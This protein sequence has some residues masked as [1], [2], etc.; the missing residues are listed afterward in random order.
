MEKIIENTMVPY[1]YKKDNLTLRDNQV[2]YL[3]SELDDLRERHPETIA[4]VHNNFVN[5]IEILKRGIDYQ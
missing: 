3:L 4:D 1:H 2:T 5:L